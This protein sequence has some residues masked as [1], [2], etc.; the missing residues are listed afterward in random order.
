MMGLTNTNMATGL[1]A[2]IDRD[3]LVRASNWLD[4][5]LATD[6]RLAAGSFVL[7]EVMQKVPIR[8]R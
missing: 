6:E 1:V 7:I 5:V 2:N 8:S 4:R 3:F